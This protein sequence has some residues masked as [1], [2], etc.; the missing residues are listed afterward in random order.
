MQYNTVI[1]TKAREIMDV[2]S[3][4]FMIDGEKS[5]VIDDTMLGE[6]WSFKHF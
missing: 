6:Q 1:I 2:Q 4:R 5:R 3:V